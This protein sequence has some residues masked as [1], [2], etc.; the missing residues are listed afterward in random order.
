MHSGRATHASTSAGR[1]ATQP[2]SPPASARRSAP[3]AIGRIAKPNAAGALVARRAP[4]ELHL[5]RPCAKG[6][7]SGRGAQVRLQLGVV[8]GIVRWRLRGAQQVAGN[9]ASIA[10]EWRVSAARLQSG[11]PRAMGGGRVRLR[12]RRLA[13]QPDVAVAQPQ[14]ARLLYIDL[15]MGGCLGRGPARLVACMFGL[16]EQRLSAVSQH[17]LVMHVTEQWNRGYV[18]AKQEYTWTKIATWRNL[19]RPDD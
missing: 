4:S 1:I 12:V 9:T 18:E 10:Y 17:K 5:G 11:P 6:P 2:A 3:S 14:F 16:R 19:Q 7:G 15:D 8:G 13:A